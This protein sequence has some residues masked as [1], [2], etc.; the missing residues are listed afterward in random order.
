VFEVLLLLLVLWVV[1]AVVGALA[2][3]QLWLALVG[4]GLFLVIAGFAGGQSLDRP[5]R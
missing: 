4:A 3:G 2:T 1:V 5:H